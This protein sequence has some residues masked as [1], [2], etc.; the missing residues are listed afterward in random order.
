MWIEGSCHCGKV[1]F[2]G[3]IDP[4]TVGL[5]HCTDC[6]TFSGSA[7]ST[8]VPVPKDSF[9]LHSGQPKVYAKVAESGTKRAQAFCPERGTRIYAAMLGDPAVFNVRVG[10]LRQRAQ[11]P[12][13]V[14]FWCRSALPWLRELGSVKQISTQPPR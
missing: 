6:Q 10:T 1:T 4:T 11:L 13:K 3:E 5:C 7:F 12:P 14:Q 2:E 8:F 9:T